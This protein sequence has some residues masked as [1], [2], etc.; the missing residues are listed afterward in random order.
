MDISIIINFVDVFD[1][2]SVQHENTY[3]NP[4]TKF[5][6]GIE[7]PTLIP[8]VFLKTCDPVHVTVKTCDPVHMTVKTCDSVHVTIYFVYSKQV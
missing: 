8:E 2:Q 4:L 6:Y 7:V 3:R 5:C 1:F